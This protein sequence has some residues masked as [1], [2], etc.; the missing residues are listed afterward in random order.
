MS[1][2]NFVVLAQSVDAQ[3]INPDWWSVRRSW[4]QPSNGN[5]TTFSGTRSDTAW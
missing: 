5:G 1:I 4:W 2:Y 3:T